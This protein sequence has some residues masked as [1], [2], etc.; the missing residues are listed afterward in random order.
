MTHLVQMA[1][2]SPWPMCNSSF[3][4]AG[5]TSPLHLMLN[6]SKLEWYCSPTHAR[7][8]ALETKSFV[9]AAV[10][11]PFSAL[12]WPSPTAC[13]TQITT[14]HHQPHPLPMPLR[15]WTP[16]CHFFLHHFSAQSGC[17]LPWCGF[18]VSSFQSFS[19]SLHAAGVMA[20]L[21]A[22]VDVNIIQLLDWWSSDK[23]FWYLHLYVKPITKNF[24]SCI[25]HANYCLVPN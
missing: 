23:I 9:W 11:I 21:V 13:L 2:S 18:K 4:I 10:A 8:M 16:W 3:T 15:F 6:N 17:Y 5:L 1:H 24:A 14:M 7:K 12:F 25:F 22:N 20:L 19:H